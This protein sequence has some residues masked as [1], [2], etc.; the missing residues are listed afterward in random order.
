MRALKLYD[1]AR[2]RRGGLHAFGFVGALR[3]V[4]RFGKLKAPLEEPNRFSLS[5]RRSVWI[6]ERV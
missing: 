1:T 5:V 6:H 3:F 2:A 4:G